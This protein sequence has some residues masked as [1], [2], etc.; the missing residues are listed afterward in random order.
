MTSAEWLRNLARN[1]ADGVPGM[2]PEDHYAWDVAAEVEQ[3]EAAM[4]AAIK[5]DYQAADGPD[6]WRL[7]FFR[8]KGILRRALESRQ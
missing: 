2:K 1:Y 3:L 8:V 5:E 7:A 6:A 4:V